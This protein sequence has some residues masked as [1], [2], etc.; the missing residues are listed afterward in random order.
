MDVFFI[1]FAVIIIGFC[2]KSE[3]V[4]KIKLKR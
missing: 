3:P 4:N 2:S 1:K